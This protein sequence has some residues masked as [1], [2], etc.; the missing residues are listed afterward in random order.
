MDVKKHEQLSNITYKRQIKVKERRFIAVLHFSHRMVS[1]NENN[2]QAEC[3]KSLKIPEGYSYIKE[4]QTTQ[5]PKQKIQKDKQR[6]TKHTYTDK[7]RI[8]RTLLKPGINSC[9]PEK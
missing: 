2:S 5:W 6:S 8:A 9:A 7:E 3:L 4:E 1:N